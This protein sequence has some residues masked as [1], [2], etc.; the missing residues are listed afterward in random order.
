[1]TVFSISGGGLTVKFR[2]VYDKISVT[3]P[4]K[5]CGKQMK[6]QRT[7]EQTVSPFNKNPD[8][9]VCTEVQVYKKVLAKLET[10]ASETK[11]KEHTC[12]TCAEAAE[13]EQDNGNV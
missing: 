3:V 9:S 6:R 7:E 8:G 4:C 5:A 12:K 2:R 11:A 10:W 1:M 13:Q